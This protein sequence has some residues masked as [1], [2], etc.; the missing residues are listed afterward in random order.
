MSYRTRSRRGHILRILRLRELIAQRRAEEL[1]SN[2][3][4]NSDP[5]HR[6]THRATQRSSSVHR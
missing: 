4:K 3:A 6:I 1:E 5:E 2:A